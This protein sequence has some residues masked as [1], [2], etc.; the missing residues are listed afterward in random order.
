MDV[1]DLISVMQLCEHYNVEISFFDQLDEVG[2]INVTNIKQKLYIHQEAISDLEKMI[3]MHQELNVNIEGID[4]A[5][6][7]LQKMNNL[8]T[9]LINLQNR[10][11]LY[12]T[13][14]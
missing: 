1:K 13:D 4:V 3:R 12:E 8:Q 5:F 6:N 14:F 10:L 7:L 2:L 9:Q 11:K